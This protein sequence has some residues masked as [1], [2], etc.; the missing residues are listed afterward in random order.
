MNW[1]SVVE[2]VPQLK[3][4]K[5]WCKKCG[6]CIEVDAVWRLEHGWPMCCGETMTIDSPEERRSADAGR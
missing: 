6:S 4:G 5:C 2:Q 3:R 1:K